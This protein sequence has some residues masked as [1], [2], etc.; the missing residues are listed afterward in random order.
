[1][2]GQ[3]K[4]KFRRYWPLIKSLQTGLLLFTGFAGFVSARCPY[5]EAS[6]TLGLLGSLF[7]AISGSTILNMVYDRDIDSMMERTC[8]RPL[9]A[10]TVSAQEAL[11]LGS[12]ISVVGVAWALI[13]DS[14]YGLVVF[15][16]LFFD[17][18]VYTL[19]LKRRT[20]WSVV[21][22]GIAGGMPVLAGRVLA[23]GM[24]D[25]VGIALTLAVLFWIPTHILTF[26]LRYQNDYANAGVPTFPSQ[27]G[28]VFTQRVIA[29]SAILATIAMGISA[30]GIGLTWGY[31][32][33]LIVL[34][35]GLFFFA[36]SSMIR[37]SMQL[38]FG[39]FKYASLYMLGSM[40]IFAAQGL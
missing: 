32:R 35:A 12:V 22:G 33:V 11:I 25:W 17:V 28:V 8:L 21:W 13:L 4:A 24:I 19:L 15:A 18:V 39:L 23:V 38:N 30:I 5:L 36:L 34:S 26:S 27:Y 40:L 10:G 37:P 14:L 2:I 1:M 16:G 3:I 7:L 20:A 29:L 31:L 6:T 9:P